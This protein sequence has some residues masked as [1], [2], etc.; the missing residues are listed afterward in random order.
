[1]SFDLTLTFTGMMLYVP[2]TAQL[3]V[4][5][6][7]TAE[8]V[9]APVVTSTGECTGG[10]STD[11]EVCVEPH[12]ARILFDTAYTR[13]G[14]LALDDVLAHVSLR[15]K[16][17]DVPMVGSTYVQGIPSYVAS[18]PSVVRQDVLEGMADEVLAARIRIRT[19]QATYADPGECWEWGGE[20]QRM[21]HQ[22][23]WTISGIEGDYVDLP[24]TDLSGLTTLGSLPRLYPVNGKV[25]L[26][27]WH[28]PAFEIPPDPIVPEAPDDGAG[29][30][31]FAHLGVLLSSRSVDMPLFRPNQCGEL[32]PGTRPRHRDRG[33]SALS[34]TGGQ[35]NGG[36]A[37]DVP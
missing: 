32:P 13:E 10:S 34:C 6:P 26:W 14:A 16:R 19:G 23:E 4:L 17:L 15:Q 18:L 2:E 8:T 35:G 12:A 3:R 27:I 9:A 11:T 20:V 36:G 24:L 33:V 25:E 7:K 29:A 5:M 31:H 28:A 22:V 30:H 37:G 21:S 1:M